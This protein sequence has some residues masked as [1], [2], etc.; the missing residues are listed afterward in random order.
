MKQVQT[1]QCA[2]LDGKTAAQY[3]GIS[4]VLTLDLAKKGEIPCIRAGERYL[5]R[6]ET[7]DSWMQ[8]QE[9]KSVEL[10][11][12]NYGIRKIRA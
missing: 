4:Y 5:F 12:N 1:I 9:K 8:E 11:K 10:E 7:L 6:K 3:L 2:T